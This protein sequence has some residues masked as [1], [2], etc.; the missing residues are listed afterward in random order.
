MKKILI[1]L[2]QGCQ[3][4]CMKRLEC[5]GFLFGPRGRLSDGSG[6]NV[7][8]CPELFISLERVCSAHS[9]ESMLIRCIW[10]G[11]EEGWDSEILFYNKELV[12]CSPFLKKHHSSLVPCFFL[13]CSML[14]CFH[15]LFAW[16]TFIWTVGD[17]LITQAANKHKTAALTICH[18]SIWPFGGCGPCSWATGSLEG[19]GDSLDGSMKTNAEAQLVCAH[20]LSQGYPDF[21]FLWDFLQL[22][23]SKKSL[24]KKVK[25]KMLSFVCTSESFRKGLSTNSNG[26]GALLFWGE[27]LS[28][29][30]DL[31]MVAWP[32]AFWVLAGFSESRTRQLLNYFQFWSVYNIS[33]NKNKADKQK[34]RRAK[35]RVELRS[36]E[37]LKQCPF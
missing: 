21:R 11:W 32:C 19:E 36:L 34:S 5:F 23:K 1:K 9:L 33:T 7:M 16:R 10:R 24:P 35:A 15:L 28:K 27:K 6:L 2:A 31:R 22:C 14:P 12:L 37:W 26:C 17:P 29:I 13:P 30:Y 3:H 25:K 18:Y 4:T 8:L 20:S